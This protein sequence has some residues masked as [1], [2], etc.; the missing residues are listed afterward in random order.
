MH[1]LAKMDS[2]GEELVYDEVLEQK[3]TRQ[4]LKRCVCWNG[5]SSARA[6]WARGTEAGRATTAADF[7]ELMQPITETRLQEASQK[8]FSTRQIKDQEASNQ[9]H[10]QCSMG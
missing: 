9:T 7:E 6:L 10:A 2:R 8:M 1:P 5:A 4:C 3:K